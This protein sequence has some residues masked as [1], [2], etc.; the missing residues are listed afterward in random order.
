MKT[1]TGNRDRKGRPERASG[2]GGWKRRVET[3]GGNGGWKER[4]TSASERSTACCRARVILSAAKDPYTPRRANS[5][6]ASR[7]PS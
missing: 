7:G 3:A 2:N 6:S 1:A 4:V 5:S